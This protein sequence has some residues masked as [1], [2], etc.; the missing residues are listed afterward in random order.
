MD[1]QQSPR[2]FSL[3]Y[4]SSL[5]L[6][7]FLIPGSLSSMHHVLS[8]IKVPV[9]G[10]NRTPDVPQTSIEDVAGYYVQVI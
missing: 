1:S 6:C 9:Y 3:A 5:F 4:S 10:L 8:E 2:S 7:F